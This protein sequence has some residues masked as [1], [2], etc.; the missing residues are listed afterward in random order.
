M[1]MAVKAHTNFNGIPLFTARVSGPILAEQIE[2][3][4]E[5]QAMIY[6]RLTG[7]RADRSTNA[8]ASANTG[9]THYFNNEPGNALFWPL[10]CQAFPGDGNYEGLNI[11]GHTG[12]LGS[13]TVES[14]QECLMFPVFIPNRWNGGVYDVIL[15]V[16][17]DVLHTTGNA[18]L[19]MSVYDSSMSA[20]EVDI[21]FVLIDTLP[22]RYGNLGTQGGTNADRFADTRI[23]VVASFEVASGSAMRVLKIEAQILSDGRS[24]SIRELV[25]MPRVTAEN[26]PPGP[27]ESKPPRW[28]EDVS[29]VPLEWHDI[30]E[31]LYANKA[32][33]GTVVTW[34]ARNDAYLQEALRGLPAAGRSSAVTIAGHD[35]RDADH[36]GK[37]IEFNL[38]A[39]AFGTLDPALEITGR[40]AK[41]PSPK[42]ATTS[43]FPAG[44]VRFQLPKYAGT[45]GLKC[46]A[47]IEK[48][49][50]DNIEVKVTIDGQ[51]K[52][53]TST[54]ALAGNQCLTSS[55]FT[56]SAGAPECD[57]L[58][59]LADKGSKN[60]RN[61]AL[62]GLCIFTDY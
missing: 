42:S 20:V 26:F 9:H 57:V 39:W 16:G 55:A 30:D 51:P 47:V 35:H 6:E 52:T 62:K 50:A 11:S 28:T 5:D 2:D 29:S 43:L 54:G 10:A 41:A 38:G 60:S 15:E 13:S 45:S 21:P 18:N 44:R 22:V 40:C 53:L 25:V 37:G 49:G 17:G 27:L 32:P 58:I 31:L 4:V 34:L 12:V 24:R 59:E 7:K 33:L 1:T 14:W 48:S 56:M 46:A 8:P 19:R 36:H 23:F 3:L 61:Q